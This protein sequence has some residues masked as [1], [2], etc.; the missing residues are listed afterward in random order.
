MIS[1][2]MGGKKS[3]NISTIN[4][5]ILENKVV[6]ISNII[7]KVEIFQLENND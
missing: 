5:Y 7:R 1:D 4:S 2:V 6:I 3:H